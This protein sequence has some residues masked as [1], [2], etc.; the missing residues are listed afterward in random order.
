MGLRPQRGAANQQQ[1]RIR[2]QPIVTGAQCRPGPGGFVFLAETAF[3]IAPGRFFG[4]V[5]HLFFS[6]GERLDGAIVDFGL[7]DCGL[8]EHEG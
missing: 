8:E 7:R 3:L 1:E 5:S 4:F 2:G 6:F